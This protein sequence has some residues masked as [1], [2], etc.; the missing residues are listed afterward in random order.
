[1]LLWF[2]VTCFFMVKYFFDFIEHTKT[3]FHTIFTVEFYGGQITTLTQLTNMSYSMLYLSGRG[4]KTLISSLIYSP[5]ATCFGNLS[6]SHHLELPHWPYHCFRLY[7][8]AKER[9]HTFLLHAINSPRDHHLRRRNSLIFQWK[10]CAS[11][12]RQQCQCSKCFLRNSQKM[13]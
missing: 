1:M 4:S 9:S 2:F 3:I 11:H 8:E 13:N 12:S 5:N 6:Q 7:N 10:S